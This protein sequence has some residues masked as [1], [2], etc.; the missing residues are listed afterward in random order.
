MYDEQRKGNLIGLIIL[1]VL[2][3]LTGSALSFVYI[4]LNDVVPFIYLNALF[5][6]GYGLLL[7]GIIMWVKKVCKITNNVA[8]GIVVFFSLIIINFIMWQWF[9][10]LFHYRWSTGDWINPFLDIGTLFEQFRFMMADN[11]GRLIPYFLDDLRLFNEQGTWTI[12]G[13]DRAVTGILL[14]LVWIVELVFINIFPMVAAFTTLGFFLHE[15]NEWAT[16]RYLPYA[17][18]EM[19][20]DDLDLVANGNSDLLPILA[21]AHIPGGSDAVHY[22]LAALNHGDTPTDYIGIY[23]YTPSD[24][25]EKKKSVTDSFF[26]LIGNNPAFI[27]AFRL[28]QDKIVLLEEQLA[29]MLV[30]PEPTPETETAFEAESIPETESAADEYTHNEQE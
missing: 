6:L 7:C 26:S 5:A 13:G 25:Q 11:P 28:G 20:R 27:R 15:H 16:P 14:A 29:K 23:R 2:L 30:E 21:Q 8:T 3:T 12:G 1:F 10:S 17:F 18:D 4:A 24:E 19:A 9:F 22:Q